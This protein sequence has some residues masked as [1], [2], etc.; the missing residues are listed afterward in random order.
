MNNKGM[1]KMMQN[2][3]PNGRRRERPLK[4][5]LEEAETRLSRRN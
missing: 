1:P 2:Y 3:W 5:L 4:T